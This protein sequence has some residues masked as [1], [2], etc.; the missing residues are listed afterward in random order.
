MQKCESC[1][2]IFRLAAIYTRAPAFAT[3]EVLRYS[4]HVQICESEICVTLQVIQSAVRLAAS[5]ITIWTSSSTALI[6]NINPDYLTNIYPCTPF[7]EGHDLTLSECPES[8]VDVLPSCV[9]GLEVEPWS[10]I[11][12]KVGHC[13]KS[14]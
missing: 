13:M 14:S 2:E 10:Q 3:V 12:L 5:A 9:S 11:S 7:I 1:I 4:R 6:Y 8:P